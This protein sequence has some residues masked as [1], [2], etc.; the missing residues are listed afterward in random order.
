MHYHV[1]DGI[2][3]GTFIAGASTVLEMYSSNFYRVYRAL[4]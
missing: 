1:G 2:D 3:S 4:Y